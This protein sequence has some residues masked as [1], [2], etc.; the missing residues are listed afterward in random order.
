M[1]VYKTAEWQPLEDMDVVM[2]ERSYGKVPYI[3]WYYMPTTSFVLYPL[4]GHGIG[5]EQVWMLDDESVEWEYLWNI[6]DAAVYSQLTMV[7]PHSTF[8]DNLQFY[9][10]NIQ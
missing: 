4:T 5:K 6:F 3:V 10:S 9:L 1:L 2:I 8:R 7:W